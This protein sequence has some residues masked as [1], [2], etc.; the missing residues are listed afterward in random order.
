MIW[1]ILLFVGII[2]AL[3]GIGRFYWNNALQSTTVYHD[4][5]LEKKM[6]IDIVFIATGIIIMLVS[7]I[8]SNIF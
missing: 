1:S 8:C 6:K 7:R 5:A 2:I 3:F 4:E